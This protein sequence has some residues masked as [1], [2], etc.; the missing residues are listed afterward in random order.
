MADDN[1]APASQSQDAPAQPFTVG[2][3]VQLAN[4]IAGT[5]V[6]IIGELVKIRTASGETVT[7]Q[8]PQV[9]YLPPPAAPPAAAKMD[10]TLPL[11]GAFGL[12]AL[13]LV[14]RGGARL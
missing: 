14:T 9:I 8:A 6:S 13:L 5:V 1:N 12:V 11:V 2:D 3:G 10:W 4:G 7:A